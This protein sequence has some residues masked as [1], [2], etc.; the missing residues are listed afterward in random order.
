MVALFC[1]NKELRSQCL[2]EP[3]EMTYYFSYGLKLKDK[4]LSVRPFN[5]SKSF[6]IVMFPRLPQILYS[7]EFTDVIV[8]SN[9][10]TYDSLKHYQNRNLAPSNESIKR[11]FTA[12]S[13]RV[14]QIKGASKGD[15]VLRLYKVLKIN[16]DDRKF[17]KSPKVYNRIKVWIVRCDTVLNNS[18]HVTIQSENEG[19]MQGKR[20]F[21]RMKNLQL[22]P[23][24]RFPDFEF[25]MKSDSLLWSDSLK[26][27]EKKKKNLQ[28]QL[29][30]MDIATLYDQYFKIH[31]ADLDSLL[32]NFLYAELADSIVSREYIWHKRKY[33]EGNSYLKKHYEDLGDVSINRVVQIHKNLLDM[34]IDLD[35]FQN[36]LNKNPI[37]T[38]F[39]TLG[40]LMA[41]FEMFD[42]KISLSEFEDSWKRIRDSRE[43]YN[44]DAISLVKGLEDQHKVRLNAENDMLQLIHR[45][46]L[47]GDGYVF[48]IRHLLDLPNKDV[49][50]FDP[51]DSNL[52]GNILVTL[53]EQ[54]PGK[55]QVQLDTINLGFD[56]NMLS[57]MVPF[58]NKLLFKM[59]GDYIILDTTQ[60]PFT[61]Q[62]I[63]IF[64]DSLFDH[65]VVCN[66][67]SSFELY[68]TTIQDFVDNTPKEY[69][70]AEWPI[71]GNRVYNKEFLQSMFHPNDIIYIH[72]DIKDINAD[73]TID[74]Y[75]F[76][77][78]NGQ[79]VFSQCYIEKEGE[80]I[81]LDDTSRSQF[82]GDLNLYR[83]M[84]TYS[85]MGNKSTISTKSHD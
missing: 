32:E 41:R 46:Y 48:G 33:V 35:Q 54:A 20:A 15:F 62:Q 56:A 75:S 6:R 65:P 31:S 78:V 24:D 14:K 79:V 12:D 84:I 45:Q 53:T 69:S 85:S 74:I 36:F 7:L 77:I 21:R 5:S 47:N 26:F 13:V 25:K 27:V 22:E 17:G 4:G 55:W 44:F 3:N 28:S 52:T 57:E 34:K 81:E 71:R 70:L 51:A 29:P 67:K 63:K 37:P 83:N 43:V 66:V 9:L 1:P 72:K 40:M 76:A 38:V 8:E 50:V 23:L 11:L 18:L 59:Y 61:F 2:Y 68:S 82:L 19:R 80:L 10:L 39:D 49:Y 42:N 30:C 64:P 58:N 73:G 60:S 16:Y